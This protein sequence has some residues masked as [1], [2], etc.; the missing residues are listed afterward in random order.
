M[1]KIRMRMRKCMSGTHGVL[2]PGEV[3][4]VEPYVAEAWLAAGIATSL[5]EPIQ[6]AGPEPV[7]E[8]TVE[9]AVVETAQIAPRRTRKG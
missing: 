5:N 9:A 4:E 2:R 1:R 8:T 7:I 6:V 3:V